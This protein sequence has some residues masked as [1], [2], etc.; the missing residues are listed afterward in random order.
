MTP[1]PFDLSPLRISLAT[2]GLATLF[3]LLGGVSAAWALARRR[4]PGRAAAD[5]AFT[6]PLVLP[7]TVVGFVLLLLVGTNGPVGK[8]LGLAGIRLVFTWPGAVLAATVAALPLAYHSA[9][10]AFESIDPELLDAARTLGAS[11]GRLFREVALPLARPGLVAGSLLAFARA[12]GEFGA[13]LMVAGNIPGETTTIPVAIFFEVEA[14]NYRAAG[15]W[16]AVTI[17]LS[18]AALAA[19]EFWIARPVREE[20]G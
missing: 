11:E 17:L 7:P 18:A 3:A 8:L 12:L 5:I 2:A 13:T 9:R 10:A 19:L 16:V 6:L 14:G 1:L 15:V 4:G 20:R